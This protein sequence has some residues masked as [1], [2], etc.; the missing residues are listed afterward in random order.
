MTLRVLFWDYLLIAPRL[1]LVLV[2]LAL[3][4]HRRYRQFPMFFAYVV[5]DFV[6]AAVLLPM[7]FSHF[8]RSV[9]YATA[10]YSGLV[11]STALRF[12]IIHEIFAHMFRN[13]AVLHRLGKPL[14]RWVTVGL[15]LVGLAV[16]AHQGR[17][18]AWPLISIV[19][20]LDLAASIL[21]C[22]LLFGLFFF[23]S[24]LGLSWRSYVFGIALGLGAFASAN[25]VAAAIRS[26]TGFLHTTLLNYFTMGTYQVCVLV[27][28]F[29]LLAPE[30][31]TQYTMK[32]LPENDLE[33][34]NQELQRLS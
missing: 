4:R 6:Q 12:G 29:Y 28:V 3:L 11:L 5:S 9:I 31:V 19:H 33:V 14:F 2:F 27:W 24:Y 23:S 8:T 22:G 15:L 13:Y 26:Q 16:A 25:L 17:H 18:D 21:Q 10:Y 30:R 7:I 32:T 20:V 1:L 34:W